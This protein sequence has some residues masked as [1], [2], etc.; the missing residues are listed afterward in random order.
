[1]NQRAGLLGAAA[2]AIGALALIQATD[3]S[4]DR[5]TVLLVVVLAVVAGGLVGYVIASAVWGVRGE[6]ARRPGSVVRFVAMLGVAALI[7]LVISLINRWLGLSFQN[8]AATFVAICPLVA[9]L[10]FEIAYGI[11]IRMGDL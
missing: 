8:P 7:A 11:P 4:S 9:L 3:R 5:V 10:A 1:M 6:R 2:L